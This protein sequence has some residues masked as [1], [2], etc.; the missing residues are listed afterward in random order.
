MGSDFNPSLR[1]MPR[2]HWP[3]AT[4]EQYPY[5]PTLLLTTCG[6]VYLELQT[7]NRSR[8]R[9]RQKNPNTVL[10]VE[11]KNPSPIPITKIDFYITKERVTALP[12]QVSC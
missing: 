10:T 4:R 7:G 11:F 3:V 9:L 5:L 2:P 1:S 6:G 8:W 12:V